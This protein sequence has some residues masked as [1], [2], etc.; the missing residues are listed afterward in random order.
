M[1]TIDEESQQQD[2]NYWHAVDFVVTLDRHY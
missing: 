2:A 1:F